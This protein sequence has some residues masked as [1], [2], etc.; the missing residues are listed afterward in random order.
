MEA[1]GLDA[2]FARRAQI[3][4][5]VRDLVKTSGMEVYALNPG[6]GI[7]GVLP[8]SDFDIE[9][10]IRRL[11]VDFGIQIAGGLGPLERKIFRIGHV[12]HVTDAEVEYFI[13]GFTACLR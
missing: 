6:N 10:F 13:K 2:V 12:G 1:Q 7:T 11:D 3:A 5:I 8:P 4:G 9:G